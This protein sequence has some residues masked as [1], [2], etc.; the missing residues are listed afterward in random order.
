MHAAV[1]MKLLYAGKEIINLVT[2]PL[3]ETEFIYCKFIFWP[4]LGHKMT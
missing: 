2:L 4:F 1:E 3:H